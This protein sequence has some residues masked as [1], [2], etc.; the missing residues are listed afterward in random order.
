M[1]Y[2]VD[3][4]GNY[5]P[6]YALTYKSPTGAIYREHLHLSSLSQRIYALIYDGYVVT[7]IEAS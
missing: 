1:T 4:N 7:R 6:E 2:H 3:T 5:N